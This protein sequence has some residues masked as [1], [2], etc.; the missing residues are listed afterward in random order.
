MCRDLEAYPKASHER[1]DSK[2]CMQGV[3]HCQTDT[4]DNVLAELEE[5]RHEFGTWHLH[6]Q[7]R[8]LLQIDLLRIDLA[9]HRLLH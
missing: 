2:F 5:H 8:T 4:R 3:R 1:A 7:Y 9:E 6:L